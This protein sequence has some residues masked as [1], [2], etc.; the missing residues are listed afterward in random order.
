MNPAATDPPDSAVAVVKASNFK[1]TSIRNPT[2]AE[3]FLSLSSFYG[4]GE[5]TSSS[6]Q[7]KEF[8]LCSRQECG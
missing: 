1:G 2:P 8:W 5:I 4:N 7:G 3:M 6:L